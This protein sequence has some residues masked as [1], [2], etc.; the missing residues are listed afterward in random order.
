MV[1]HRSAGPPRMYVISSVVNGV[2]LFQDVQVRALSL[3]METQTLGALTVES[4]LAS[5]RTSMP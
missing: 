5:R 4:V 3:E 1:P 2:E